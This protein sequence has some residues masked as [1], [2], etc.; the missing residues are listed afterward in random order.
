MHVF[1]CV[2]CKNHVSGNKCLAF[3]DGIPNEIL[4]GENDHKKPVDGD[5]GIRFEPIEDKDTDD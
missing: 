5:N 3:P 2:T 4:K 1:I